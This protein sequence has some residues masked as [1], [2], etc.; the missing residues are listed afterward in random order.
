MPERFEIKTFFLAAS[1]VEWTTSSFFPIYNLKTK[2]ST[3][4]T[5]HKKPSK[6]QNIQ[7]QAKISKDK[8]L[9]IKKC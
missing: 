3:L 7:R 9:I 6:L 2:N 5:H 1:S 8:L 4:V